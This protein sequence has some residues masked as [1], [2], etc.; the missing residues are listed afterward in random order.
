MLGNVPTQ[1]Y[2]DLQEFCM[3]Q[4]LQQ[5]IILPS[6]GRGRWFEPSIAHSE[7]YCFAGKNTECENWIGGCRSPLYTVVHQP[8]R[9]VA[10]NREMFAQRIHRFARIF[11][12][13]Q[14]R[15]ILEP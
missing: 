1:K 8:A 11:E 3:R 14:T 15:V 9:T 10:N 5:G 7:K 13:R 12:R 2:I 6:H 4:N